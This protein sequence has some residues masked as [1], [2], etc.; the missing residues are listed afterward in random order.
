LWS[1]SLHHGHIYLIKRILKSYDLLKIGI[2]SSQLSHTINDPFTSDE[3]KQFLIAA[4]KKREISPDLYKIFEI[5]D[6]FNAQQW[7][8]HVSSI[9]G[10]FDIVYSN[11]DWVRQLFQRKGINLGEKLVIFKNK[12]N[13]SHIRKLMIKDDKGWVKLIPKEVVDLINKFD[14]VDRVKSSNKKLEKS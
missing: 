11:S 7:P 10:E 13:G 1:T 6:I 9:V 2:G 8:T 5:P 3:R 12:F 14:G 4:L